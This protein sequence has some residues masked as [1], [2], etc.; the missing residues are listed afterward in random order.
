MDNLL[1]NNPCQERNYS[2]PLTGTFTNFILQ[3]AL[4]NMQVGYTK[5]TQE[6]RYSSL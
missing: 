5:V 6:E 4:E 3:S 1:C 2:P